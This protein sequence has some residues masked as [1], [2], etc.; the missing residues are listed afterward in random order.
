MCEQYAGQQ[1]EI[2]GPLTDWKLW[3][4]GLKAIDV[5]TNEAIPATDEF[6]NW[7]DWAQELL[8]MINPRVA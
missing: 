5:F 8:S 2:P 1:I 3:G 6:N 7:F 4:N